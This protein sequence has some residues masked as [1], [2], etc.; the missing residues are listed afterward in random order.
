MRGKIPFNLYAFQEN[1][2]DQ[3]IEN[4][5]NIILKSRQM[6]ISTLCSSYSLVNM[7]MR[8]GFNILVIATTKDVAKNLVTKVKLAFD[9]LPIWLKSSVKVVENNKLSIVFDNGSSIKAVAASE[10]AGRSE[11]LSLLIIDE[12]AFIDNIDSIWTSAQ[13]T[14]STGG[15]AIILSTPNGVGNLFHK[16]WQ[17]AVEG[18]TPEGLEPFNAIRLDWFLHPDRDQEWRDQQDYLLGKRQAAQECDCDFLSSGNSLIDGKLLEERRKKYEQEPKE[19]R[20]ELSDYWIWDYPNY[21]KE[22]LIV[23]DV[24][25]GDGD[26]NSSFTV[27][28][29]PAG[30]GYDP[31]RDFALKQVAEYDGKMDTRLFGKFLVQ[32]GTEWNNALLVIDNKNIG[33]DV[34]QTVIDLR[35]ENLF[36]AQNTDN[37]LDPQKHVLMGHDLKLKNKMTPGLTTTSKNRPVMI[38]KL[39]SGIRHDEFIIR[40]KRMY[41]QLEVFIWK[42]GKPQARD[43]Y[44]D[45]IVMTWAMGAYIKDTAINLTSM[46]RRMNESTM[47]SVKR[48]GIYTTSPK[49]NDTYTMKGPRGENIDI[50]WL[51]R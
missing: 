5:F 44:N 45:D 22:Y 16:L 12:A 14:L 4:R 30:G 9:E 33:W 25:R 49:K 38:S 11:A 23:A 21:S 13:S 18:K 34:I 41:N 46:G 27:L 2:L 42:N 43:G 31:N 20:G 6:G 24:G 29:L 8:N 15:D 39:T 50:G 3:L 26:D 47:K 7:L 40:S 36:Y 32:V 35:Y 1:T 19:K 37:Y 51:A 48:K 17:K 10:T 28:E